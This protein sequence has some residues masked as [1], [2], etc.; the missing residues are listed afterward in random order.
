MVKTPSHTVWVDCADASDVRSKPAR[1]ATQP[2]VAV[3]RL[4]VIACGVGIRSFVTFFCPPRFRCF[5]TCAAYGREEGP[6]KLSAMSSV[7]APAPTPT[8]T[9]CFP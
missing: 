2:R 6:G 9:Y 4:E 7:V 8:T 1:E 3:I 5:L